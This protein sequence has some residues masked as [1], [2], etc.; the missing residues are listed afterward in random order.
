MSTI[1]T[2]GRLE[3]DFQCNSLGKSAL[4]IVVKGKERCFI[5]VFILQKMLL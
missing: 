4:Q 3:S 5:S 1:A 2:S